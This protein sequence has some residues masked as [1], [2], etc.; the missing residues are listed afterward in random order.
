MSADI[1]GEAGDSVEQPINEAHILL[2]YRS[3]TIDSEGFKNPPSTWV[4][5]VQQQYVGT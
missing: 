5:H 2:R 3:S 4:A 1:D